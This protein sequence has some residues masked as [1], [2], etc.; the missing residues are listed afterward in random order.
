LRNFRPTMTLLTAGSLT[1]LTA[2]PALAQ[3]K[4]GKPAAPAPAAATPAAATPAPTAEA[5]PEAATSPFKRSGLQLSIFGGITNMFGAYTQVG[6]QNVQVSAGS[7][8]SPAPTFPTVTTGSSTTGPNTSNA[9]YTNSVA[10]LGYAAGAQL[11]WWLND[12][13]ALN[14]DYTWGS[15]GGSATATFSL[16]TTA[17][18]S[19]Y[20]TA[21]IGTAP[22]SG[23]ITTRTGSGGPTSF[24]TSF[25]LFTTSDTPFTQ[26]AS[27]VVTPSGN[28]PVLVARKSL[29]V[30]GMQQS[31]TAF[32]A[33]GQ[34]NTQV[35]SG[36]EGENLPGFSP[37]L[38]TFYTTD[39]ILLRSPSATDSVTVKYAADAN[40][41]ATTSESHGLSMLNLLGRT[42]LFDNGKVE[43]SFLSGLSA[44]TISRSAVS[45]LKIANA[46]GDGPATQVTTIS[47]TRTT[48]NEGGVQTIEVSV[49]ATSSVSQSAML[50]GP[51]IGLGARAA[52]APNFLVYSNFGWSPILAG[53]GNRTSVDSRKE[54]VKTI[55]TRIDN[56][57]T[58]PAEGSTNTRIY[59][60]TTND[61]TNGPSLMF[62]AGEMATSANLGF[63][64]AMTDT[65]G[66]FVEGGFKTFSGNADLA[67]TTAGLNAGI[68]LNY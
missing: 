10:G 55:A 15:N 45:T 57:A 16:P 23:S 68:T 22:A 41:S 5:A 25:G 61:G 48:G 63:Q 4:T 19:T 51:M 60:N 56:P 40:V 9:S 43:L 50:F 18:T 27:G 29:H 34:G 20:A 59:D 62:N 47:D 42:L 31:F 2:A 26:A 33:T 64:W 3:M 8:T 67:T 13:F 32:S 11:T 37:A 6:M 66:L 58:K 52:L 54:T 53:F 38:D 30:P 39:A 21:S 1:L 14:L 36:F 12:S 28:S 17:G 46:K 65:F 49:D 7:S 24:S 35:G 44:P